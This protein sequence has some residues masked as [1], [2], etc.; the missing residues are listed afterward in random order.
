M[1]NGKETFFFYVWNLTISPTSLIRL[2]SLQII[3]DMCL[4]SWLQSRNPECDTPKTY[5]KICID[6]NMINSTTGATCWTGSVY[7]SGEHAIHCCVFLWGSTCFV[8]IYKICFMYYGFI[9]CVASVFRDI[10]LNITPVS[11]VSLL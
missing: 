5:Y 4:M 11:F 9:C 8:F 10:G 2:E 7:P 1:F 6:M 3:A